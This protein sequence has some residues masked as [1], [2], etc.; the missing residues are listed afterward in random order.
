MNEGDGVWQIVPKNLQFGSVFKFW[1]F[2][3]RPSWCSSGSLIVHKKS[4]PYYHLRVFSRWEELP[5]LPHLPQVLLWMG[6]TTQGPSVPAPAA[7]Q[8]AWAGNFNGSSF[9][10]QFKLILKIPRQ[11]ARLTL[12]L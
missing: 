11:R 1:M 12:W 2:P 8:G 5:Y 3:T 10:M 9:G 4:H 6:K 7:A